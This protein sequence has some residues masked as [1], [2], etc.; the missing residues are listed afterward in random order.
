MI[1]G[2]WCK[3]RLRAGLQNMRNM[4]CNHFINR[5]RA[6]SS[7]KEPMKERDLFEI[8]IEPAGRLSVEFFKYKPVTRIIATRVWSAKKIA[9]S[10]I[11]FGLPHS[12]VVS[13]S[14]SPSP[15]ILQ[16]ALVTPRV[17]VSCV[18]WADCPISYR[19]TT[20]IIPMTISYWTTDDVTHSNV[21]AGTCRLLLA[22]TSLFSFLIQFRIIHI[23]V[24]SY[25]NGNIFCFF[26]YCT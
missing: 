25:Y 6:S 16:L 17:R 9:I 18:L 15:P 11:T 10:M 7:A 2:L 4:F 23:I 13:R 26:F 3:T 1:C 19:T 5:Y 22:E 20:I 21:S 24:L 8:Y 12:F 14:P